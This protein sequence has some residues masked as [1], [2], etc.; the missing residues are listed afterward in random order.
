[1]ATAID[2]KPVNQTARR[3][4]VQV[5]AVMVAAVLVLGQPA[6]AAHDVHEALEMTGMVFLLACIFGRLWA[7]LYVGGRKNA[8]LVTEGPFSITRNP[9]Y[10]FSCLGA[11]GIGLMFGSV[12]A[13]ALLFGLAFAVLHVTA[14]GEAAFL[15][16]RFGPAYAA[17]AARTPF[18]WP[19]PRLYR[20]GGE[21]AAFSPRVLNKTFFDAIWFLAAFPAVEAVEAL[22][23]AGLLPTMFLLF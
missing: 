22:H 15:A 18:F 2:I 3:H 8:E 1:M 17:Y 19:D 9:L 4:L 20:S 13:A 7:I 12:I 14:R 11:F 21:F 16:A 10:V 5:G 23:E 6:L